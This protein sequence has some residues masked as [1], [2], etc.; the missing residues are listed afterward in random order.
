MRFH[1]RTLKRRFIE[2]TTLAQDFGLR[3]TKHS[4]VSRLGDARCSKQGKGYYE[5]DDDGQGH[6]N[7][8]LSMLFSPP[9]K[10][11]I[12]QEPERRRMIVVDQNATD[13]LTTGAGDNQR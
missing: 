3:L 11:D 10:F 7:E 12:V 5:N 4:R 8:N 1:A 13:R 2:A 9:R 6:H